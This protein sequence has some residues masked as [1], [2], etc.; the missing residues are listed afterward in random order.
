MDPDVADK[1]NQWLAELSGDYRVVA[2][3]LKSGNRAFSEFAETQGAVLGLT[4]SETILPAKKLFLPPAETLLDFGGSRLA[5]PALDAQP[6]VV[7]GLHI[8]EL[9][10]DRLLGRIMESGAAD[11]PYLERRARALT[12]GATCYR[13]ELCFCEKTGHDQVTPADFDLFLAFGEA[14]PGGSEPVL[15]VGSDAGAQLAASAP[16]PLKDS[17]TDRRT[18]S[19]PP[20]AGAGNG[21]ANYDAESGAGRWPLDDLP[22]LHRDAFGATMW[23]EV[24]HRCLGCGNCTVVC[25]LCYCFYTRDETGLD[26]SRGRRLRLWDSCQLVPF[27]RVAG[28]H[29]FREARSERIWYRFSHKFMRIQENFGSP[30]CSGCGACLHFCPAG[31]DPRQVIES[32]LAVSH[33]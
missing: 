28:G 14:G 8:C 18:I 30:G 26:P 33:V 10:A 1:L 16:F 12:I 20:V 5:A 15:I 25:P 27:A 24:A 9:S 7:F 29:N 13:T 32:V 17:S 21:D 4:Q 11:A 22:D 31:I 23:D 19:A 2:P 3:A 6:M